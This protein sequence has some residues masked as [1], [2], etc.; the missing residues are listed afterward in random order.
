[1]RLTNAK[2]ILCSM[3]KIQQK[4][5]GRQSVRVYVR[6]RRMNKRPFG[7]FPP[8]AEVVGSLNSGGDE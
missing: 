4:G 8:K 7:D 3:F 2:G 1:M 5:I 6:E